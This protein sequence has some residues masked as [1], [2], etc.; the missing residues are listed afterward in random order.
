VTVIYR[1]CMMCG[2]RPICSRPGGQ[3]DRD[4]RAPRHDLG[5]VAQ[6][7]RRFD[8]DDSGDGARVAGEVQAR[9]GADLA[10]DPGQVGE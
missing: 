3:L 2:R 7:R 5:L 9:L 8:R 6:R 1:I 10:H 4:R